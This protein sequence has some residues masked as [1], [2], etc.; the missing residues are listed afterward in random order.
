M[1]P[2]GIEGE[3]LKEIWGPKYEKDVEKLMNLSLLSKKESKDK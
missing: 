1:L 3:E 2:G